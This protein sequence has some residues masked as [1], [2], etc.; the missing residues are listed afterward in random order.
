M[1]YKDKV[2]NKSTCNNNQSNKLA[3]RVVKVRPD[4]DLNPGLKIRNLKGYP[5]PHRGPAQHSFLTY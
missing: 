5:L 2:D 1:K 4:W 3:I